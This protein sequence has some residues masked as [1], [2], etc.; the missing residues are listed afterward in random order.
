MVTDIHI[1]TPN[2]GITGTHTAVVPRGHKE[3]TD[4]FQ[5]DGRYIKRG[6]VEMAANQKA[7]SANQVAVAEIG[8]VIRRPSQKAEGG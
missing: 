6:A 5:G 1:Y 2:S 7:G 8:V 4:G 3:E